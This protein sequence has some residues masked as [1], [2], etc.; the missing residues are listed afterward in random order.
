MHTPS[1]TPSGAAP[2][3][4][5]T[6]NLWALSNYVLNEVGNWS[7]ALRALTSE[8]EVKPLLEN[9]TSQVFELGTPLEKDDAERLLALVVC[10][11][12]LRQPDGFYDTCVF[13]ADVSGSDLNFLSE[14]ELDK[15]AETLFPGCGGYSKLSDD[16][17]SRFEDHLEAGCT[18][19]N[20]DEL[21]NEFLAQFGL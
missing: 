7:P 17:L 11:R 18:K 9:L 1:L 2:T 5:V 19:F 8:L 12:R 3:V 14:Q 4:L 10:I 6:Q 16:Q 20:S 21:I 15:E 13:Y